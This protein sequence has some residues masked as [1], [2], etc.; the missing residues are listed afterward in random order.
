VRVLGVPI[1]TPV[2]AAVDLAALE[3]LIRTLP[4]Q[5]D[6]ALTLAEELVD[7]GQRV[8]VIAE[9]LDRRAESID[10]LG[11]RLDASAAA[12]LE[13][14]SDMRDLGGQIDERG[15]E[16][17]SQAAAVVVAA[18]ELI[19][20]L[21]TLERALDLASPLEGAIDRFGRMVDRFPGGSR[22][23]VSPPE[24]LESGEVD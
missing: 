6:R 7:I 2:D 10:R 14:G 24:D 17:V 12:L 23:P 3:K 18:G 16:I 5:F 11:E 19:T 4:R 8:L 21:P 1:Y 9:R 20:V 13:L 22:R 15:A